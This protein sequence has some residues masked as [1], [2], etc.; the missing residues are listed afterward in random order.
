MKEDTGF[1]RHI[2]LTTNCAFVCVFTHVLSFFANCSLWA[3]DA[4]ATLQEK[5]TLRKF[6]MHIR[7]TVPIAV[8]RNI[9]SDFFFG[10]FFSCTT[11]FANKPEVRSTRRS[12]L[13][14]LPCLLN[15]PAVPEAPLHPANKAEKHGIIFGVRQIFDLVSTIECAG[16][17]LQEAQVSRQ[18]PGSLCSHEVPEGKQEEINRLRQRWMLRQ[19]SLLFFMI[20]RLISIY[21]ASL[22]GPPPRASNSCFG[23][24]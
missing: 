6:A 18:D 13:P 7:T 20:K 22:I 8:L 19:R 21:L 2:S 24:R 10:F 4:S 15:L 12:T 23:L 17:L 1:I 5:H 3:L 16:V 11:A 14:C 9:S